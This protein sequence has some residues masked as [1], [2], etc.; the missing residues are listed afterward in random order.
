MS[1]ALDYARASRTGKPVAKALLGICLALALTPAAAAADE[2]QTRQSIRAVPQFAQNAET[3]GVYTHLMNRIL[4]QAVE[5]ATGSGQQYQGATNPYRQ[6]RA[7]KALA[8]CIFWKDGRISDLRHGGW[9]AHWA[10]EDESLAAILEVTVRNCRAYESKG[11]A[12][13]I[14]DIGGQNT[15]EIPGGLAGA[16]N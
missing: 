3:Q 9:S 6:L 4:G 2:S 11:C 12:C 1:H 15:V 13:Q 5:T 7:K 10:P 8:A 16:L 14:I